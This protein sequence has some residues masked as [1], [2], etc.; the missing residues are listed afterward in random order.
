MFF[1]FRVEASILQ[2]EHQTLSE[3]NN[4]QYEL[5]R[6]LRPTAQSR[7]LDIVDNIF[8]SPSLHTDQPRGI[9]VKP[10]IHNSMDGTNN[11]SV[12]SEYRSNLVENTKHGF[13]QSIP[14]AQDN[15]SGS[16]RMTSQGENNN[17]E[18]SEI[19]SGQ[20]VLDKTLAIAKL[21]SKEQDSTSSRTNSLQN[22][23]PLE[24]KYPTQEDTTG[25]IPVPGSSLAN[26]LV[27]SS[28]GGRYTNKTLDERTP[29]KVTSPEESDAE[30]ALIN[31]SFKTEP[32]LEMNNLKKRTTIRTGES[33]LNVRAQPDEAFSS[34]ELGNILKDKTVQEDG[35]NV[36]HAPSYNRVDKDSRNVTSGGTPNV[37]YGRKILSS[38][39][40]LYHSALKSYS[41]TISLALMQAWY[42]WLSPSTFALSALLEGQIISS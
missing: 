19:S 8:K 26:T 5:Q 41:S 15:W 18:N 2:L 33:V 14:T 10:K 12:T 7:S 24:N 22:T 32:Q 3:D 37:Y 1:F 25:D 30:N 36:F 28:S 34:A 4:E 17:K 13:Q 31:S 21:N 40:K 35:R 16:S 29:P 9:P 42:L 38:V 20:S 11:P 39:S 27:T 23:L 6:V